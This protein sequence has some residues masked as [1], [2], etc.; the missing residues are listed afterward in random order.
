M[1]ATGDGGG[2]TRT[3]GFRKPRTG[4][5]P[6]IQRGGRNEPRRFA[7]ERGP[8]IPDAGGSRRSRP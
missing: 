6:S 5:F 2:Q 1:N 8:V 4:S 7:L 3:V